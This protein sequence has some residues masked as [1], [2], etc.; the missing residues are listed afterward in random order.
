MSFRFAQM[1]DSHLYGGATD[2]H[3]PVRDSYYRNAARE[4]G[5]HGVDFIV[6]TGDLVNGTEGFERHCRFHQL[7]SSIAEE[8]NIPYYVVR[9][10]HDNSITDEEYHRAHGD[11]SYWFEHNGWAFVALDRYY[12]CYEHTPNYYDMNPDTIDRLDEFLRDIPAN[13]PM[14][15]LLHEN[16][17]GVTR[18]HR[19]DVL[20]HHLENHNLQL[21][22]F[23]HVQCN[24]ISRVQG[25]P[26]ATVVG[27]GAPFDSAPLTYNIVTCGDDGTATCAFFPYRTNLPEP[28]A[29]TSLPAGG[30][31]KPT[32]DWPDMRGPHGT[33]SASD[34]LPTSAP[35]LAWQAELP[36][37][38]SVGAPTLAD[39]QLVVGTKTNGSFEECIV[40]AFDAATGDSRWILPADAGVEGGVLLRDGR[41][42]FGTTAGTVYCI[43]LADGSVRWQWNNRENLPVGCEPTL[44]DAPGGSGGLL[45]LGA[46]WEMYALDAETGRRVW[47]KLVRPV[48]V[49]YFCPGHASPLIVGDRVYHQRVFN[50]MPN[51]LMQAVDKGTGENF[52]RSNDRYTN[53]PGQRQSSPVL[54]DGRIVTVANG[55]LV[56]D[57]SNLD[58]A[59]VF[60]KHSSG[61]TTP[62]IADGV[63]YVSYHREIVAHDLNAGGA[64]LWSTLQE[65]SR[66]HFAGGGRAKWGEGD[67][68]YGTYSAPLVAGDKLLVCDGGG[69]V[70]CL[71]TDDGRE[72]WRLQVDEPILSAP[73]VS[74][75]TLYVGDYA[76]RLYAFAW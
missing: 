2:D 18:F 3:L 47:R 76:G 32:R 17:I 37:V 56:F 38:I 53:F 67:L 25:V 51:S 35:K 50:G 41:G 13:M 14:V 55:L 58:E 46:N 19:G 29:V 75:N 72:L 31:A 43:D 71:A 23:G 62:A 63:A 52:A 61:A 27:E 9:G 15:L 60:V 16:P 6:H 22:L 45:H 42:Y 39:G 20:L 28:L 66:Y 5:A 73:I 10:N 34:P 68:P 65:P 7:A 44:D 24:Y 1:T 12:R 11:G 64:V 57:P 40:Q 74:G 8:L 69:N 26:Y 70:R 49:S 33:R 21:V 30:A 54:Y 59:E 36:G 4:V 48:G